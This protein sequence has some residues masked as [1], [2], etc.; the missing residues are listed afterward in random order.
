MENCAICHQVRGKIGVSIGPDLGTI[1]NWKKEDIMANIL[2]PGLSI[3][4][5]YELWQI[6]LNNGE[7]VQGI[8]SSETPAAITLKNN[9][10]QDITINRQDVKSL[11]SLNISAM[12]SGLEKNISKQ[13]M[14]DLI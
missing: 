2:N 11:K 5:G 9:G 7:S 6:E 13:Q 3:Y 10:K 4:P 8:I 12:P 1:H 14:A